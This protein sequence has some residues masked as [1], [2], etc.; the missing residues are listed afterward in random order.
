MSLPPD[1]GDMLA[2]AGALGAQ[3]RAPVARDLLAGR[4]PFTDVVLAGLGG[5]AAGARLAVALLE[6]E[7]RMPVATVSTSELPGWV[8]PSTLVV[9]TSYSGGTAEALDWWHQA[10]ARGAARVAVTSGGALEERAT[11]AGD[12]V[13]RV[14]GGYQPRGALGLLLAPLVVLLEDAG[15]ASGADA[16]LAAGA[17]AADR[18]RDACGSGT[19][20]GAA[21]EAA[22]LVEGRVIVLYGAGVLGAVALRLKNQLNENA[23]AP[24][25]AGSLPE[26]AH[27][28]VLGWTGA[29]ALGLPLVAVLLRDPDERRAER[30]VADGVG[31]ELRAEGHPVVE[32]TGEGAT[33]TERAFHLLSFGDHV[34]CYLGQRLGVDLTDIA[35]L[36]RL[37][38][39]LEAALGARPLRP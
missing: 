3:L 16:L 29:R 35:R 23:N 9:V 10:G 27:N 11:T 28:E 21:S 38:A 34:S 36:G 18:V 7:L 24:A 33:A 12:G 13:V 39:R 4:G 20:G 6:P 2:Q 25:F 22:A 8:G 37:K 26:V 5:S 14:P 31:E 32:W 17:V 15:A 19:D 30:A 1:P